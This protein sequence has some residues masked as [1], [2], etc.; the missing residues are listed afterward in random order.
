M[1]IFNLLPSLHTV[2]L[3]QA[4][5]PCINQGL[6]QVS[7]HPWMRDTNAEAKS[8]SSVCHFVVVRHHVL[9]RHRWKSRIDF[10][11][12]P[13]SL[14]R[15]CHKCLQFQWTLPMVLIPFMCVAVLPV[16]HG[17]SP[18]SARTT[19]V[20]SSVTWQMGL[21]MWVVQ[22]PCSQE[23]ETFVDC[24][25]TKCYQIFICFHASRKIEAVYIGSHVWHNWRLRFFWY[26]WC[27]F[28][29]VGFYFLLCF[30]LSWLHSTGLGRFIGGEIN[31]HLSR[32]FYRI[33][34]TTSFVEL[35]NCEA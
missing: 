9:Y 31:V 8:H 32:M 21:G 16:P 3:V 23:S 34:V 27:W 10:N 13:H 35:P 5:W 26:E 20:S 11:W 19:R 30:T 2:M 6:P 4:N 18:G 14:W 25:V 15:L 33:Q 24:I 28:Q 12:F 29:L 22:E 1:Y 7:L 17:T